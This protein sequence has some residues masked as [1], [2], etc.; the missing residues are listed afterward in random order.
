MSVISLFVWSQYDVSALEKKHESQC[1][2]LKG[3]YISFFVFFLLFLLTKQNVVHN[4]NNNTNKLNYLLL[5]TK[6]CL[7]Y[8]LILF[9]FQIKRKLKVFLINFLTSFL[10]S[11]SQNCDIYKTNTESNFININDKYTIVKAMSIKSFIQIFLKVYTVL[12]IH[13]SSHQYFQFYLAPTPPSLSQSISGISIN[14]KL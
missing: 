11:S 2:A 4:N 1:F 12:N 8:F 5:N 9:Y 7:L 3:V 13:C 6:Y 14:I 10:V